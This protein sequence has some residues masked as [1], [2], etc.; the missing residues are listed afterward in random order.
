MKDG[1]RHTVPSQDDRGHKTDDARWVLKWHHRATQTAREPPPTAMGAKETKEGLRRDTSDPRP[2]TTPPPNGQLEK[3]RASREGSRWVEVGKE[4][5]GTP[6]GTTCQPARRP[7]EHWHPA[8][9]RKEEG[10]QR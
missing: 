9:E 6:K 7:S 4:G 2:P 3:E 8:E 10:L 5:G 1:S